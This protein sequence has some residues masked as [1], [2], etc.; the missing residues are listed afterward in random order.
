MHGKSSPPILSFPVK[1]M[2]Q[3]TLI[4]VITEL[5]TRI[6]KIIRIWLSCQISICFLWK[7]SEM[8][9]FLDTEEIKNNLSSSEVLI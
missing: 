7:Y 5:T 4:W 3:D 2:I 1:V 6:K 8:H 9:I